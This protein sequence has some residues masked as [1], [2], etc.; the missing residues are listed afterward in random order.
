MD[1]IFHVVFAIIV[2]YIFYGQHI[3]YKMKKESIASHVSR[4]SIIYIYSSFIR[5]SMGLMPTAIGFA[6]AG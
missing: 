6:A 3:V 1:I 5:D 4:N 2:C